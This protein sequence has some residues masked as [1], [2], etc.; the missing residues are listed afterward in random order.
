MCQADLCLVFSYYVWEMIEAF[1]GNV[2][3]FFFNCI[4]S[5]SLLHVFLLCLRYDEG[6]SAQCSVFFVIICCHAVLCFVFS[7]TVCEILH[8]YVFRNGFMFVWEMTSF[9]VM[10]LLSINS[11]V[12]FQA[13]E[14]GLLTISI[15]MDEEDDQSNTSTSY[16]EEI[17]QLYYR[18]SWTATLSHNLT[19]CQ[20]L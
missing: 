19:G 13:E 9:C 14:E 4:L 6:L 16:F 17:K 20:T 7:Y 12:C 3:F 18:V 2:L 1:R 11:V 15:K 10:W 5:C 8:F